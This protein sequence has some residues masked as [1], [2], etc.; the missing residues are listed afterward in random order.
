MQGLLPL[1]DHESG[2]TQ[3]DKEAQR[4]TQEKPLFHVDLKPR[5]KDGKAET[6]VKKLHVFIKNEW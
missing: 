1:L 4:A 6:V 5:D 2:R 3:A